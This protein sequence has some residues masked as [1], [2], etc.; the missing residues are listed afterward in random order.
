MALKECEDI[1]YV[2][3]VIDAKIPILKIKYKNY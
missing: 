1:E 2:N 3:D